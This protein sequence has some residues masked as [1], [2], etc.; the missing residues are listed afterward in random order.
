MCISFSG[1]RISHFSKTLGF[2]LED[3]IRNQDL[4][5]KRLIVIGVSLLLG[6]LSL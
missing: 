6:P 1:S 4:G 3:G 2:L 5:A